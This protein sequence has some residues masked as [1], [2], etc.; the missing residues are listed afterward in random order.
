MGAVRRDWSLARF[1]L[2]TLRN[3]RAPF[4]VTA[5]SFFSKVVK[6][7]PFLDLIQSANQKKPTSCKMMKI[8][9]LKSLDLAISEPERVLICT[10]DSC[11]YA[12]QVHDKRVSRHLWEKHQ[13]PKSHR[14]GLDHLTA[15][16]QLANPREVSPHP[17][18]AAVHPLLKKYAG[19]RVVTV[20]IALPA[21]S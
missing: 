13:V 12:L 2:Q 8:E 9:S 6:V 7:P 16:L 5:N 15:S 18:G 14:R 4:Q 11:G 3:S 10:R 21:L 19:S 17:D 20:S 1:L